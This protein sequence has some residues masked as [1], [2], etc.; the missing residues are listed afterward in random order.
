MCSRFP[1]SKHVSSSVLAV[2]EAAKRLMSGADGGGGGYNVVHDYLMQ[3]FDR[4]CVKYRKK[5]VCIDVCVCLCVCRGHRATS[6][7]LH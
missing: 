3:V 6:E 1:Q 5:W 7:K 4:V 2:G